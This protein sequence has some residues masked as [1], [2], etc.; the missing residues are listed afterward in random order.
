MIMLTITNLKQWF[1]DIVNPLSVSDNVKVYVIDVLSKPERA[2]LSK[3]SVVDA[4]AS[5][6]TLWIGSINPQHEH[7]NVVQTFGRLSYM[8][9]YR[10]LGRRIHVYEELADDLPQIVDQLQIGLDTYTKCGNYETNYLSHQR[11]HIL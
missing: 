1:Y 11:K 3:E 5:A 2:D 6:T 9:C 4:K 10:L 8:S 7:R